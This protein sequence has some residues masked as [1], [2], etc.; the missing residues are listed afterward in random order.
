MQAETPAADSGDEPALIKRSAQVPVF[1]GPSRAAAAR[2]LL[3]AHPDVN[4]L[5][6]D[7][8]L[9]HLAL[10]RDLSVAVFRRSRRGQWMAA[11]CG[12]AARALAA[13]KTPAISAR[14]DLASNLREQTPQTPIPMARAPLF[15]ARRRLADHARGPDDRDHRIARTARPPPWSQWPAL[16][17]PKRFS[18]CCANVACTCRR[19][20]PC[21]TTQTAPHSRAALS[22][23]TGTLICTEKD[24]VKLFPIWRATP[25]G[26][27]PPTIWTIPLELQPEPG[28]FEALDQRLA[29][30]VSTAS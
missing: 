13:G 26:A 29:K 12:L 30:L 18:R 5:L 6:C 1:V 11:A 19:R 7:D 2:A 22:A 27:R 8:G 23:C 25:E 17:C 3:A 20:S 16:R 28:F 10:G 14:P 4:L 21:P 24:A 9:Q 15:Q